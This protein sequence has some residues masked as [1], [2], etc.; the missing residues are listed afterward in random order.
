MSSHCNEVPGDRDESAGLTWAELGVWMQSNYTAVSGGWDEGHNHSAQTPGAIRDAQGDPR[1][2]CRA[3]GGDTG[4]RGTHV[5][6]AWQMEA[7]WAARG[8]PGALSVSSAMPRGSPTCT[9][10]EMCAR[11]PPAPARV[12]FSCHPCLSFPSCVR[13]PH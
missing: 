1:R 5:L 3:G 9:V 6:L 7:R 13:G 8:V 12:R 2:P 10:M 11:S 4:S